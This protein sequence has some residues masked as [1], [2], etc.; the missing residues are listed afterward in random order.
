MSSLFDSHSYPDPIFILGIRPRSGTNFLNNLVCLHPDCTATLKEDFLVTHADLLVRYAKSVR[1]SW[2][3]KKANNTQNVEDL[4]CQHIGKGLISFLHLVV[5]VREL[6]KRSPAKFGPSHSAQPFSMRLVTKT[7]NVRNLEHFFKLFPH[8]HLLIIV[9]DGRAV[10]ESGMRTFHWDWE[11]AIREW[12]R[13]AGLILRFARDPQNA[14]RKYRILRYE[15]LHN[16]TER[17]MRKVL[18]FLGLDRE[19]YDFTTALNM[20]VMGSSTSNRGGG[21]ARWIPIEKNVDFDPLTRWRDWNRA[22]HERFNWIA[23]S[24]LEQFGY[25]KKLY[26]THRP[27]WT[28]WNMALDVEWEIGMW[29]QSMRKRLQRISSKIGLQVRFWQVRA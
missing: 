16:H 11:T 21:K 2:G 24:C 22:Q 8:A 27:L 5:S 29:I 28:L 13:A 15:D 25:T 26:T 1:T 23:G 19:R 10:V 20:P 17:E 6:T 14:D 3:I 12:A 7:P 9:R 18:F 4:L